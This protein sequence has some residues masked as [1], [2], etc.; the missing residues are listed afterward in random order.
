MNKIIVGIMGP[1]ESATTSD[2]ETAYQLGQQLGSQGFVVLTGGRN[3]GVMEAASKGASEAG[4]TTMG[5]LPSGNRD[6][7][8][9]YVDIPVITG[10]GQARN[11][12]NVLTSDVIVACGIGPGTASEISL[13]IKQGKNVILLNQ[14]EWSLEFFRQLG[15]G[16]IRVASDPDEAVSI[17]DDLTGK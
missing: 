17:I 9:E 3:S 4:G 7:L 6:N 2:I 14:P 11:N 8:S 16:S 10:L 1:G 5:V 12:I 15:G 13:A